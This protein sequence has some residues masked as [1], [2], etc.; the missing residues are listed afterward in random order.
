MIIKFADESEF[1]WMT[2]QETSARPQSAGRG[3]ALPA[4]A[5]RGKPI[6]DFNW[7]FNCVRWSKSIDFKTGGI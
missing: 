1:L 5:A 4:V 2:T 6:M 7:S 3:A